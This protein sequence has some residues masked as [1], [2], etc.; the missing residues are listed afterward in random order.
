MFLLQ[1]SIDGRINLVQISKCIKIHHVGV[2]NPLCANPREKQNLKITKLLYVN[3]AL[4]KVVLL[5]TISPKE[6][7]HKA[8][9]NN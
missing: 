1:H 7:Q 8:A 4:T 5:S 3:K 2:I 9:Q 6:I